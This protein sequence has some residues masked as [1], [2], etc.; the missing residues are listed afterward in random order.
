MLRDGTRVARG[1]NKARE[2]SFS[3]A[4]PGS[5]PLVLSAEDD[6]EME[7]WVAA[8][9]NNLALPSDIPV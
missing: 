8:I 1:E 2:H 3:I 5:K 9:E 4:A 7:E 6:A